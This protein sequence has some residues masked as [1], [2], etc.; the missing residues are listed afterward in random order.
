MSREAARDVN[1]SLLIVDRG[2]KSGSACEGARSGVFRSTKPHRKLGIPCLNKE[3][4][5]FPLKTM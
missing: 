3:A 1:M 2:S 5:L 4:Y